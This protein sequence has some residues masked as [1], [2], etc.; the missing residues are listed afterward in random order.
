MNCRKYKFLVCTLTVYRQYNTQ[1][2]L[3]RTGGSS[4]SRSLWSSHH[5]HLVFGFPFCVYHLPDIFCSANSADFC[6]LK[7]ISASHHFFSSLILTHFLYCQMHPFSLPRNII[8]EPQ[9]FSILQTVKI[10]YCYEFTKFSHMLYSLR[11]TTINRKYKVP[12]K[13]PHSYHLQSEC[14]IPLKYLI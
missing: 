8:K 9:Q 10:L 7:D 14:G 2:L 6:F 3:L 13:M 11:R 4:V 12:I 5:L 1:S